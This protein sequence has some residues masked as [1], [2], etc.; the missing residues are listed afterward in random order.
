MW[1]I[2]VAGGEGRRFGEPKQFVPLGGQPV[3][4]RS[5]AAARTVADGVV[6]VVPPPIGRRTGVG[7][8]GR[9][10]RS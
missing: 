10:C 8:A 3:V 9:G 5:V 4:G 1:A 6:V 7:G 2:V